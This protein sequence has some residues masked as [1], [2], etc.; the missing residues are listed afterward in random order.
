MVLSNSEN[1]GHQKYL[2]I[3]TCIVK[4]NKNPLV[5]RKLNHKQ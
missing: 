3:A 4:Q 5:I 1:H 2:W